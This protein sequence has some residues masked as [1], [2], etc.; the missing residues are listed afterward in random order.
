MDFTTLPR[1][2]TNLEMPY[3]GLLCSLPTIADEID[4]NVLQDEEQLRTLRR[5][6][7]IIENRMKNYYVWKHRVRN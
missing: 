7:A 5:H 4:T 6:L 2:T 1:H 3:G